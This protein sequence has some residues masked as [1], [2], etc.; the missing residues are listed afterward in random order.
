MQNE[1]F[2]V[3]CGDAFMGAYIWQGLPSLQF[4]YMQI[5]VHQLH[6]NK[7]IKRKGKRREKEPWVLWFLAVDWS[8]D[9]SKSSKIWEYLS[10][11]EIRTGNSRSHRVF[12]GVFTSLRSFWNLMLKRCFFFFFFTWSCYPGFGV[13]G[14]TI[15]PGTPPS[16]FSRFQ[17]VSSH[18]A[19]CM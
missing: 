6:L 14:E 4:R 1:A 11:L 7:A 9:T 3:Y 18:L 19:A 5:I 17:S 8:Q 16:I 2:V 13:F 10:N 12:P 15:I